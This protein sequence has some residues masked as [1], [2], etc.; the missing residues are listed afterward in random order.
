MGGAKGKWGLPGGHVDG[1]GSVE[2]AAVIEI[3]EEA[4]FDI[5]IKKLILKKVLPPI[6]YYIG[7]PGV[8]RHPDNDHEV[9]IFLGEVIGGEMKAGEQEMG[10]AWFDL[11]EIKKLPMRWSWLPKFLEQ[12]LGNN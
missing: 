6:G 5:E 12:K 1:H 7:K 9:N 8:G 10:V 11:F 4:G 2:D 3:K